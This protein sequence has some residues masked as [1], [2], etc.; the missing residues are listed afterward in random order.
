MEHGLE[1]STIEAYVGASS[2]HYN[3]DAW[4]ILNQAIDCYGKLVKT[5]TYSRFLSIL[6][7]IIVKDAS[8]LPG[9]AAILF[10][11]LKFHC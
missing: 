7:G 1:L 3:P 8:D 10:V 6:P 11:A 4:I 5:R 2:L 9:E